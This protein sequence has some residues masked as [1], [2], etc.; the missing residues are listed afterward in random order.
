MQSSVLVGKC[1]L[2]VTK[3]IEEIGSTTIV[4]PSASASQEPH[5]HHQGLHH[6]AGATDHGVVPAGSCLGP[7]GLNYPTVQIG[8]VV[9]CGNL[10][11]TAAAT[12]SWNDRQAESS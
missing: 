8:L 7:T 10:D 9:V 2:L 1:Y 6:D 11:E 4:L 5:L 3:L 12:T